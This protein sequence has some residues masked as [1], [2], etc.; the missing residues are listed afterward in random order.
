[1]VFHPKHPIQNI[2][3]LNSALH[4]FNL[5]FNKNMVSKMNKVNDLYWGDKERIR[6]AEEIK[7]KN[8]KK[9]VK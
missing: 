5:P 8:E 7:R 3:L 1:M 6:R 9:E 4:P 2:P